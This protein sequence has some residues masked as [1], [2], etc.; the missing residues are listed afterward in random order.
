MEELIARGKCGDYAEFTVIRSEAAVTLT[1]Q[2]VGK[3]TDAFCLSQSPFAAFASV[4]TRVVVMEGISRVGGYAFAGFLALR[5]VVLPTTLV[6]LGVSCFAGCSA[7]TEISI[8]EGVDVLCPK[9]F[10]KCTA[11]CRVWLPSTLRSVDFKVFK[12]APLAEVFYNGTEASWQRNVRISRSAR[13]NDAL[14]CTPIRFAQMTEVYRRMTSAVRELLAAG[15]DGRL[16]VLAPDLTTDG[17]KGKSGDFSL[18]IFPEGQTML[19]DAGLPACEE[20]VLR[21]LRETGLRQVDYFVLSHPHLDH[22]G[23]ALA[24]AEYLYSIGGG[25]GKYLSSGCTHKDG[26]LAVETFL[27]A[28]AC[29]MNTSV[30]AGDHF[31]C[32]GASFDI[33]NPT[34]Q[35]VQLE[36]RGEQDANNASLAMLFTFGKSTYLSA[37]DLYYDREAE[38]VARYGNSLHAIAAKANHHGCFTSNTDLWLDT[39]LPRVLISHSDDIRWTELDEKLAAR[40]ISHYRVNEHGLVW[41]TLGP[42][43]GLYI[44]TEFD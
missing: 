7:L 14:F 25:I 24:V 31:E 21:F 35:D 34:P 4:V 9:V 43:G 20:K 5:E 12:G 10:D 23:N 1:V 27:S 29:E 28:R 38:L 39:V 3:I 18:L 30:V 26:T 15:G 40:G 19:I 36:R 17:T 44:K 41:L 33:Y 6:R 2:G 42:K 22:F 11:L 32:G 16:H 8:P 13:G 37:G